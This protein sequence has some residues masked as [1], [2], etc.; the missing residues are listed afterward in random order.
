MGAAGRGDALVKACRE[1]TALD[2]EKGFE[3]LTTAPAADE[4]AAVSGL[5][6]ICA[7]FK[8]A[9]R[10]VQFLC[11]ACVR[12]EKATSY[13]QN[14]AQAIVEQFLSSF[15]PEAAAEVLEAL[16]E[17]GVLATAEAGVLDSV[18]SVDFLSRLLANQAVRDRSDIGLVAEVCLRNQ[19]TTKILR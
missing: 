6:T 18:F 5:L 11:E 13:F 8:E 9:R 14:N 1:S 17:A 2:A 19:K 10:L 4:A 3:I 15:A 7:R 12:R 16:F